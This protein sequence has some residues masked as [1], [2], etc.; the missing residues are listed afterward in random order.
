MY[1]NF[2]RP[3]AVFKSTEQR[4]RYSLIL[5]FVIFSADLFRYKLFHNAVKLCGFQKRRSASGNEYKII[6]LVTLLSQ[7]GLQAA[8]SFPYHPS[9]AAPLYGAANLFRGDYA[10]AVDPP[11]IGA[12]VAH[13]GIVYDAF[14]FFE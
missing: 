14:S 5:F 11:L 1:S 8:E 2:G 9:G 12:E 7:L 10:Q 3:A 13:K 6:A 4:L